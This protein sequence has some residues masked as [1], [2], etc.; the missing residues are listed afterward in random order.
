MK[1]VNIG[2]VKTGNIATSLVLELLLDERADRDDISVRVISS[3]AKMT[4]T[5]ASDLLD[6]IERY[7]PDIVLYSTPNPSAPGPRSVIEFLKGRKTIVIGDSPGEKMAQ[8]LSNYGMGYIFIRGDAMIGARREF[9]DPTE[10]AIFNADML[11]VLAVTGVFRLIQMEINK[12]ISAF[13]NGDNYLP[14]VIVKAN[15]ALEHS[16]I[17]DVK[18]KDQAIEAYKLAE[19]VGKLNV[20]G[21]FIEKDPDKYISIVYRS[22]ELLRKAGKLADEVRETEN[23]KDCVLRTPH[24]TDGTILRKRGLNNKLK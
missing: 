23:R 14:N 7:N 20:R 10:M 1:K 5:E 9:L 11:K 24:Y 2:V 21:C 16:G 4:T 6:E 8:T 17:K 12:V 22:H 18:A 3:G 13:K 19:D 15:T